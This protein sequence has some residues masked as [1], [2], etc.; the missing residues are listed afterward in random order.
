MT[1][2]SRATPTRP[3]VIAAM[4]PYLEQRWGNHSSL[5]A[6]RGYA[7]ARSSGGSRARTATSSDMCRYRGAGWGVRAVEVPSEQHLAPAPNEP[8]ACRR[9]GLPAAFGKA[10]ESIRSGFPR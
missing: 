4:L 2:R 9:R 5:H 1:V 10:S 6:T 8:P 7:L 3:E